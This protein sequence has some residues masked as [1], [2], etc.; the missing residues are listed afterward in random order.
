M[1]VLSGIQRHSRRLP[2]RLPK[3]GG[4]ILGSGLEPHRFGC[5]IECRRHIPL[6][7]QPAR[8]SQEFGLENRFHRNHRLSIG[9][10][11]RARTI[12][13]PGAALAAVPIGGKNRSS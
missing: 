13:G 2:D 4:H 12:L 11:D 8:Q 5:A 3:E 7:E 10:C 9:S 1:R 6:F